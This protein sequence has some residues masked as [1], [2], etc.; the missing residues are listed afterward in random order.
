MMVVLT[1]SGQVL[2]YS[3]YAMVITRSLTH[4]LTHSTHTHTHTR[5]HART[6]MQAHALVYTTQAFTPSPPSTPRPNTHIN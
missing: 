4:S 3:G 1:A 6:H 2:L 5:T